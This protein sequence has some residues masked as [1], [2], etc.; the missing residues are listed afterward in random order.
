MLKVIISTFLLY[1]HC[2]PLSTLFG[3][4]PLSAIIYARR[5]PAGTHCAGAP[6]EFDSAALAQ[7]DATGGEHKKAPTRGL[8]CYV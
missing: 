2:I 4:K 7:D 6:L 8:F 5:D 3:K 1:P